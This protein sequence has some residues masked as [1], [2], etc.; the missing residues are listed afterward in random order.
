MDRFLIAPMSTGLQLNM[1]PWL[2]MDDAFTRLNNA[3]V[4]RSRLRKR[5]GAQW[6]NQRSHAATPIRE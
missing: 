3:Y 5:F 6:R 4:W 1:P 2:I